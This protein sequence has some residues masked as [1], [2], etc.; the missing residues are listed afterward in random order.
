MCPNGNADLTRSLILNAATRIISQ[1]GL[2]ALTA[3]RL[4]EEAGVSK[5]GLYHHFRTMTEVEIEVLQL[6]SSRML[7][8]L[9]GYKTPKTKEE[10]LDR[11]ESELFDCLITHD[12]TARALFGYV[13]SSTYNQQVQVLLRQLN[14]DISLQRLLILQKI[15]GGVSTASLQNTVQ[16]I[17]TIQAGL[18]MRFYVS[19]DPV[20]VR[21]YWRPCRSSLQEL[22]G[23]KDQADIN[24]EVVQAPPTPVSSI[25]S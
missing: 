5:G 14:D 9:Q 11:I 3:G 2:Q 22:L 15:N 7:L 6:L 1:D 12:E 4:I 8:T 23:I 20:S 10:F 16:M 13:S 19:E 25:C 24:W 17:S 18:M 21:N